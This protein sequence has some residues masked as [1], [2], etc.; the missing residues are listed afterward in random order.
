MGGL[1]K[2]AQKWAAIRQRG[3]RRFILRTG[4]LGWGVPAALV[5]TAIGWTF[6]APG[7]L[8]GRLAIALVLFPLTGIWFGARMWVES[9]RRY[10]ESSQ[11]DRSQD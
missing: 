4:V 5:F 3:R 8:L 10:L 2:Q 1:D 9:E 7:P 11:T 6:G